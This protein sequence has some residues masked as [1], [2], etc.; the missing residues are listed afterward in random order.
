MIVEGFNAN[1]IKPSN[2]VGLHPQMLYYDPSRDDGAN[3]GRNPTQTAAPAGRQIYKWYAGDVRINPNNT[4]TLSPI[5]FGATN[6]ISSDRILHAS[7][8]AIG[9]LIIEPETATWTVDPNSRAVATVTNPAAASNQDAQ[10]KELVLLFQND[11]NMRT[12]TGTGNGTAVKNLAE[13]E[14]PEDS[15]QKAVNYRT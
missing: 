12:G 7:K 10:F 2:K 5:E 6:L 14:D 3:I 11:V 9:A 4:L 8:G 15:G 1:D 13:A